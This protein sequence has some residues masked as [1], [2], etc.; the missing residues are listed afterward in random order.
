MRTAEGCEG[1]TGAIIRA[2]I[3]VGGRSRGGLQ[4]LLGAPMTVCDGPGGQDE[5]R[6][7]YT[8][9][10]GSW[11]NMAEIELSVLSGQCLGRRIPDEATLRREVEALERQRNDA[12]ATIAWRFTAAAAR[13]TL[14]HLYPIPQNHLD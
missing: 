11:L 9:K 1:V 14:R 13:T 8:P 3:R 4:A 2:C 7:H 12:H 6:V 10:H 5:D